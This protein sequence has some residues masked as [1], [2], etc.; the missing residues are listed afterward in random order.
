MEGAVVLPILASSGSVDVIKTAGDILGGAIGSLVLLV[1][2][3]ILVTVYSRGVQGPALSDRAFFA[4]TA[5]FGTVVHILALPFTLDL[6]AKILQDGPGPHIVQTVAWGL[7]VLLGLPAGLGALFSWL[8]DI[9]D[10]VH[11]TF[12]RE[13]LYRLGVT[14]SARTIQ[15]WTWAFMQ[16]SDAGKFVRVHL[17]DS[18]ATIILGRYG[19]RSAA[20]SD[21]TTHDLFLQELWEDDGDGWFGQRRVATRGAW[22]AG[23]QIKSIEFFEGSDGVGLG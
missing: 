17:K 3:F 1:P 14:S 7:V 15:A 8:S 13:W 16:Q 20:S 5:I 12:L 23:D 18:A 11:P 9:S 2:G 22:I 21:P 10:D 6:G 4:T 19:R